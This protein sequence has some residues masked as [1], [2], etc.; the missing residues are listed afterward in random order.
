M[1]KNKNKFLRLSTM[2]ENKFYGWLFLVLLFRN[3]L[4]KYAEEG[5]IMMLMSHRFS[6]PLANNEFNRSMG[7][8]LQHLRLPISHQKERLKC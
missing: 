1:K 7:Q 8:H 5:I 3:G 6:Q 2:D 4:K